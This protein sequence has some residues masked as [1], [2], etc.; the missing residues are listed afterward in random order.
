[1][2]KKINDL[3]ITLEKEKKEVEELLLKK[4]FKYNSE[5]NCF[6]DANG[7]SFYAEQYE[8]DTETLCQL[9]DWMSMHKVIV[10]VIEQ[11]KME[12]E[13]NE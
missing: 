4:G 7:E 11:I 5:Y 12:E 1:M 8:D 3:L 2:V 13:I 6:E 10:F 9:V